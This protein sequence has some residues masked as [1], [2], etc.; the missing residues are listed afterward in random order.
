[1]TIKEHILATLVVLIWGFNFVVIRWGVEDIHPMTMT[2][3]RFVLTAFPMVF[4]V[5]KPDVAMRYVVFYGV[6]FGAGVWGLANLA[7]YLGTSAGM[8]SLLLQL[9]P[10]LTVV[11]AVLVFKETLRRRQAIGIGIALI[12]FLAIC[13]FKSDNLSGL[14]IALMLA[15]AMFWT[16]CNSIIKIA[17]PKNVVSFTVCSSLFIPLPIL[18]LSYIY[19][20]F[21]NV[22]F[23]SLIQLPSMKGWIS[24]IFQSVIVTLFGYAVWTRLIG[25]HGLAIVTPYSLLVPISGL[26][27][28]WI[29]Y[30]ETLSNIELVGSVLVLIGLI[31]LTAN[32][33]SL[34][35]SLINQ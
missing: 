13:V 6:M 33:T 24:I 27:F 1:M 10:F 31:M 4:L 23:E 25:K 8:A 30:D 17:K 5:K 12:G 15:S 35:K 34:K 22:S 26:F 21:Y 20:E 32:F 14:G 7:V 2:L 3:L 16:I 29:F 28:G 18:A 19:A 9:S 11:V